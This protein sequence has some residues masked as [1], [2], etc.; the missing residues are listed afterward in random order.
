MDRIRK[1]LFVKH[2]I[3]TFYLLSFT[4]GILVSLTGIIV[5]LVLMT[6]GHKPHKNRYGWYFEL[7]PKNA[8]FSLGP[9]AIIGSPS[10]YLTNHEFGHAIQNCFY[11]PFMIFIIL[12][13]IIRFWYREWLVN[14]KEVNRED[15]PEYDSIWFEHEASKVGVLYQ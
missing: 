3:I 1:I 12:A 13:S 8:G 10:K 5:S 2:N 14:S 15:L 4:W 11:G 6:L 7:G 9:M